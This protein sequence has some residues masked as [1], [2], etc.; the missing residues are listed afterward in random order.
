MRTGRPKHAVPPV[1]WK[2]SLPSDLAAQV[3]LLLKDPMRDKPR[4]GARSVLIEKL[5]RA[6]LAGVIQGAVEAKRILQEVKDAENP[7]TS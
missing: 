6:W 1:E 2:N 5:L 3:E 7:H 4:Y